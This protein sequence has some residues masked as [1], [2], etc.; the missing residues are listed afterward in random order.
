MKSIRY[1]YLF[2]TVYA[3]CELYENNFCTSSQTSAAVVWFKFYGI[4]VQM[5]ESINKT[6]Y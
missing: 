5:I 6:A 2:H 1:N 4:Y 3:W